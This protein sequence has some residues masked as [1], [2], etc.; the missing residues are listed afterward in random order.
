MK[1]LPNVPKR[2]YIRYFAIC[3][4]HSLE[5]QQPSAQTSQAHDMLAQ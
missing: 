1:P 2:L 3:F 5:A 4:L